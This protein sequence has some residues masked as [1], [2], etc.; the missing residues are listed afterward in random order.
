MFENGAAFSENI[1]SVSLNFEGTLHKWLILMAEE[2][3]ADSKSLP[4]TE[5]KKGLTWIHLSDWHQEGKKFDRK[6]VGDAL[7]ADIEK[8]EAISPDLA[9]IDFIVFSGDVSNA[10]RPNEYEDAIRELFQPLLAASGVNPEKL[11][12]IPGNHDL[13]SRQPFSVG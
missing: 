13:V 11:F 4:G 5:R 1:L 6:V 9:D 12:I 3:L 8:R 7:I 2:T 10:G